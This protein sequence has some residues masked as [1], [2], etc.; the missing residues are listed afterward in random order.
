MIEVK[1]P[2]EI[3]EY[4]SKLIAG[5][6]TR[7]V[8]SIA[9]ALLTGVPIAMMG[10]GHISPDIL[11]WI[12]IIVVIPFAGFGFFTFKGMRFEEFVKVFFN[13]NFLPQKRVY[14]DTDSNLFM[15][16]CDEIRSMDIVQ[17]RI[18]IGEYDEF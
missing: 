4:K 6:S 9:G 15:E 16:L 1:I 14:E 11:P 8:I 10:N 7:Q 18:D 5:L 17:Q 3:Q 2:S 13:M 12:V